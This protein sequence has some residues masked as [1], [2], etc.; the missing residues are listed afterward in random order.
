MEEISEKYLEG[1]YRGKITHRFYK[2]TVEHAED[3]GVHVEG[4]TPEKLLKINRPNEQE[5]IRSYRLESYQPVTQSLSEKVINTVNKVFNPRLWEFEFPEMT[6]ESNL[7]KYLTEDYPSYRTIMNFITETFTVKDFSDP[8]AAIVVIPRNFNI[9]DTQLFEPVAY[10]YDSVSLIDF[11][12]DE[13]Y[14]FLF[15]DIIKIFTKEH[16]QYFKREMKDGKE[17]FDLFFE[18]EHDLGFVPVFRLGGVI[19]GKKDPFYYES[20]IR[21]VLPHWNQVVQLTSDAQAAYVNHLYMDKWEFATEC[22]A[23]GCDN[24]QVLIEIG[25]GKDKHETQVNCK[26]CLGTGRVSRNPYGVHEVNRDA[27]NP[28]SPLPTPPAGYIAKP[29]DVIDKVE[30]RI[31]KEEKRGFAS[32]NMEIVQMVGEDQ[33][34]L[35]KT[36]DREDLNAFLSRY[37]RHVFEYVLPNLIKGIAAWRY[38]LTADVDKILP[39]INQPKDFNVL[40]LGQLASEYKDA[41]GSNV[42][43]GYL[44]HLENELVQS[45]FANNDNARK[46]NEA[47]IKLNPYP[48]KSVDDLLTLQNLGEE[49]WVIYKAIHLI[50]LVNMAIEKD[51]KFIDLSL[52]KQ[53]EIIDEMA[54]ELSGFVE[55]AE[56]IPTPSIEEIETPIQPEIKEEEIDDEDDNLITA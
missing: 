29:I 31:S 39:E 47:L 33:S 3:M 14:T 35:A 2:K 45:K 38:G 43:D 13:Y 7:A 5:D 11:V 41:S 52:N 1:I 48:G 25:F 23:N 21:G 16:I 55:D 53:R 20:W 51:P 50:E 15:G 6:T 32:I 44:M 54:K 26:T 46:I 17:T 27:L 18:Y 56:L 8:N 30:D 4:E 37:S 36:V 42:S 19:K 10:V 28:D 40:S 49:S 24:G 22:D 9:D 12:E 34:G